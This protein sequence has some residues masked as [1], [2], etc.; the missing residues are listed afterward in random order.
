VRAHGYWTIGSRILDDEKLTDFGRSAGLSRL[1]WA[2]EVALVVGVEVAV[3]DDAAAVLTLPCPVCD[4]VAAGLMR[5]YR[6]G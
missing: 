5:R 1:Y 3:V 2:V 6:T 4:E